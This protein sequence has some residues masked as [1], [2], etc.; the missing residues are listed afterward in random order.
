MTASEGPGLP[1]EFTAPEAWTP[2][3]VA[4]FVA[5]WARLTAD[6]KF[7]REVRFLPPGLT[8]G[9]VTHIA[10]PEVQAGSR[11]RQRCAWC[12][13]ILADTI[14]H[15]PAMWAQGDLVRS[16]GDAWFLVEHEEDAD[17]P[18]DSCAAAELGAVKGM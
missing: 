5:E 7:G 13:V 18:A 12:G 16:D 10:G 14:T 6:P 11:L 3:Q 8:V 4:G 1:A 15:G 2:E 9:T 17:L